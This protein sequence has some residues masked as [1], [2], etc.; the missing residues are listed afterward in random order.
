MLQELRKSGALMD[1]VTSLR[2][3]QNM[4]IASLVITRNAETGNVL[5]CTVGLREVM[6]AT[7]LAIGSPVP[8][9]VA[10]NAAAQKAKLA[11]QEASAK[12]A[13]TSQ[14]TLSSLLGGL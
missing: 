8:N 7:S 11:K 5:D 4:A 10:N 9:D 13:Q 6:T 3:Y 12:Q 14:S 1:A 2:S